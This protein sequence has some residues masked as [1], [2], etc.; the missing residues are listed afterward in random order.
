MTLGKFLLIQTVAIAAVIAAAAQWATKD[1]MGLVLFSIFVLGEAIAQGTIANDRLHTAA[2]LLVIATV[3]LGGAIWGIYAH[4]DRH[5]ATIGLFTV[6]A[7]CGAAAWR[8]LS[9]I[10]ASLGARIN[11]R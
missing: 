1:D 8:A 5:G 6:A 9:D 3:T 2:R 10:R 7:L 11:E 4:P